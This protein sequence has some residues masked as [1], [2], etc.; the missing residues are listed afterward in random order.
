MRVLILAMT[1]VCTSLNAVSAQEVPSYAQPSGDE[2]IRGRIASF[3]G[4]YNL[5]VHDQRGFED[6]IR[7]HEGTIINPTGLEL[8][9][10]MVVSIMGY[11]A[12]PYFDANEIDTPY[13]FYGAV[14]YY[15]G[16]PW[17]YYGPMYSLGFFFGNPVWWN[18]P[19]FGPYHYGD[20][21]R[22]RRFYGRGF[23]GPRVHGGYHAGHG[24]GH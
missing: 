16:R 6:H 7:L 8:A 15:D 12:G 10:G 17:T 9:S 20:Y 4:G 3:D 5:V 18:R 23:V 21:G 13:T 19:F 22:G 24:H 14:P 11:N 2:Q 1:L